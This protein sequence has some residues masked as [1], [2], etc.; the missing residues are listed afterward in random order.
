[1]NKDAIKVTPSTFCKQ[2]AHYIY[3]PIDFTI[4]A[5]AIA[6]SNLA[7][8]STMEWTRGDTIGRGASATVSLAT[9]A[10]GDRLA[11]KSAELA[12]SASLQGEQF[13]LSKLS[14]PYVVEYMG[15]DVGYEN[16]KP[17]YN[18]FMEYVPGGT[19]SDVIKKRGGAFD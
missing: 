2:A 12:K 8:S 15:F 13:F 17:V 5:R 6:K 7:H 3:R 18:L 1:M 10:S 16:M 4:L 19:L 14:S 9:T 11:V